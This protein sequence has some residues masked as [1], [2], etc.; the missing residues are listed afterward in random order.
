MK[1][2]SEVNEPH[3]LSSELDRVQTGQTR[4]VQGGFGP[5]TQEVDSVHFTIFLRHSDHPQSKF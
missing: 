4:G 3:V 2:D 5:R 1:G